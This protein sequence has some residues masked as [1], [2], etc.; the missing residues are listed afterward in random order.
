[1]HLQ[2][3]STLLTVALLGGAAWLYFR[4][5]SGSDDSGS[6]SGGGGGTSD[7]SDPLGEARKIMDK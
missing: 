6:S 5:Q 3:L 7:P 1:M 2:V 4:S